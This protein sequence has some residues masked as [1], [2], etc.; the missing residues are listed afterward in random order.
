M[1]KDNFRELRGR[2]VSGLLPWDFELLWERTGETFN[3]PWPKRFENLKR[4]GIVPDTARGGGNFLTDFNTEYKPSVVGA[5]G[6]PWMREKIAWIA[7]KIG[8]FTEKGHNFRRGETVRKQV[9]V[10]N[11]SRRKEKI[12]VEWSI[13]ELDIREKREF[14]RSPEHEPA[15][16]WSSL[17][18]LHIP[19]P[20]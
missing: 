13:P 18:L 5:A 9:L 20:Y 4:P 15:F 14:S 10:L 2:G 3:G 19:E 16:R 1:V 7:G 17:C 6:L 8:D 11:D 12:R